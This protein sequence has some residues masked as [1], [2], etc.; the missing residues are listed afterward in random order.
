M[1]LGLGLINGIV[2]C[3]DDIIIENNNIV[4]VPASRFGT[5]TYTTMEGTVV[6]VD[7]ILAELIAL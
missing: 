2:T 3:N 1:Y 4:K 6:E 5:V 7:S